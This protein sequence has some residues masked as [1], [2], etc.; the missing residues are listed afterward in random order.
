MYALNL[1]EWKLLSCGKEQTH[2]STV[3]T[4]NDLG[5]GGS[6][7]NQ[8]FLLFLTVVYC[9]N[10]RNHNLSLICDLPKLGNWKQSNNF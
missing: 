1:V 8:H 6:A 3:P 4:S 7:C 2:Y 9:I 5:K 10:D